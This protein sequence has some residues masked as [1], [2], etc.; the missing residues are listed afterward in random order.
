[1][2]IGTKARNKNVTCG[3]TSVLVLPANSKR[4]GAVLVND[5]DTV[6]YIY[7]GDGPAVVNAG[8]RLN[9]SGGAYEITSFNN[10]WMGQIHAICGSATKVLCITETE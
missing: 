1:M 9:A 3:T 4:L 7:L 2:A 5:S 8:I 10:P 6:I